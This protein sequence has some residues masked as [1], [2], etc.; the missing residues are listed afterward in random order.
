VPII[1]TGSYS[2]LK[3]KRSAKDRIQKEDNITTT[4]NGASLARTAALRRALDDVTD[5]H[6]TEDLLFLESWEANS[7]VSVATVLRAS[8][9]HRANPCLAPEIRAELRRR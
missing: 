4:P 3:V 9:I 6:A 1:L 8:Q 7:V 2:Y 5:S